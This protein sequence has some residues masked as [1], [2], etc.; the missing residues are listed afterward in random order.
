MPLSASAPSFPSSRALLRHEMDS[1][2]RVDC[3]GRGLVTKTGLWF[4]SNYKY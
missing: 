2:A 1:S 3:K 4:H